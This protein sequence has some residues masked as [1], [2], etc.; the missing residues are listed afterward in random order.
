M[1]NI[2]ITFY[3]L[4]MKRLFVLLFVPFV[5]LSILKVSAQ[6]EESVDIQITPTETEQESELIP[7]DSPFY[8]LTN[9]FEDVKLLLTFDKEKRIEQTL[10]YAQKKLTQIENLPQEEQSRVMDRLENRFE[11]LLSKA[12]K[13]MEKSNYSEE[14][15]AQTTQEIRDRHL[16]VLNSVLERVPEGQAQESI[17]KVITNTETRYKEKDAKAKNNNKGG[18]GNQVDSEE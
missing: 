15:N 9:I 2:L 4:T 3:I 18:N 6:E 5:L 1:L 8:F 12:E 14:E 7:V 10:E 13:T 11:K 17:Q 16:A